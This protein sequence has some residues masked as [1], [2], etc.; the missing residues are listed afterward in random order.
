MQLLDQYMQRIGTLCSQSCV[1]RGGVE[2]YDA[3]QRRATGSETT[4]LRAL[5]PEQ[6]CF[7]A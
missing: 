7:N 5:F 3:I 1:Q 6:E 4:L 2:T